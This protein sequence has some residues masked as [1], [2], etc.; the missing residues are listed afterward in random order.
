MLFGVFVPNLVQITITVAPLLDDD[1]ARLRVFVVNLSGS[2]YLL[3]LEVNSSADVPSWP[4]H[5]DFRDL[6]G[7]DTPSK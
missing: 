6:P 3:D 2:Q 5:L 1:L 7:S 4:E